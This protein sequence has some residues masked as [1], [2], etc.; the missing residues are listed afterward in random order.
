MSPCQPNSKH[1]HTVCLGNL[2]RFPRSPPLQRLPSLTLGTEP[3]QPCSP[4]SLGYTVLTASHTPPSLPWGRLAKPCLVSASCSGEIP[5]CRWE[6]RLLQAED[7]AHCKFM[8]AR[9]ICPDREELGMLGE[10]ERQ[11]VQENT[12]HN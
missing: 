5:R 4:S 10:R 9:Q 2:R 12:R 6:G 3:R 11:K 7:L 1:Q 8:E